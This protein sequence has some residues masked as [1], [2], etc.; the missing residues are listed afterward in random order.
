[1]PAI[2]VWLSQGSGVMPEDTIGENWVKG[3]SD[4]PELFLV[5]AC[6]IISK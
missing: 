3:I 2:I 1:M 6:I 4:V 5:T